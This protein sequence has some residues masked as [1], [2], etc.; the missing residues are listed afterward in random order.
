MVACP[1]CGET[2]FQRK[3]GFNPSG[4]Q[5]YSCNP[6]RRIYPPEP[7]SRPSLPDDPVETIQSG[8]DG[9]V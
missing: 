5:R 1:H 3:N 8:H 9:V 2:S 7:T 6:C 4:S